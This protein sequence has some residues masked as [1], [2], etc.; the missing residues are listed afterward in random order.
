MTFIFKNLKLKSL[1]IK[2]SVTSLIN[3]NKS[4]NLKG[5]NGNYRLIISDKKR[6]LAKTDAINKYWNVNSKVIEVPTVLFLLFASINLS[7]SLF[8]LRLFLFL[9]EFCNLSSAK[10]FLLY[11]GWF[12]WDT[13]DLPFRSMTATP[14]EV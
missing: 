7:P 3:V 9:C 6:W 13:M 11:L 12:M 10:M 1:T 8:T 2:Q 14:Q 5:D 4:W